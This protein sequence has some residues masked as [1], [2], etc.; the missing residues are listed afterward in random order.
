MVPRFTDRDVAQQRAIRSEHERRAEPPRPPDHRRSASWPHRAGDR[1]VGLHRQRRATE[2]VDAGREL[3]D[4][5]PGRRRV[6]DRRDRGAQRL[7]VLDRRPVAAHAHVRGAGEVRP[8]GPRSPRSPAGPRAPAG[9][10]A[11]GR[12]LRPVRSTPGARS[13]AVRLRLRTSRPVSEPSRTSAPVIRAPAV[14]H[15][16][17]VESDEQREGAEHVGA[18]DDWSWACGNGA[19]RR[20]PAPLCRRVHSR[21]HPQ[22]SRRSDEPDARRRPP[23]PPASRSAAPCSTRR[24]RRARRVGA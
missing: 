19:R 16:G 17:A 10:C 1:D 3:D 22:R 23:A 6:G 20:P 11:A 24:R 14:G 9:P 15:R 13:A 18:A 2:L 5:R 21:V 12:A 7:A 4:I 8:A